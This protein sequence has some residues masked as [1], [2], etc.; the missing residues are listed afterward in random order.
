M[1]PMS[2]A[3]AAHIAGETTTLATCWRLTRT[4]G[5]LRGFTD[6]DEDLVIDGLVYS[7][8]TGFLPTAVEA[9]AD[10][11]VDGLDV[12]GHLDDEAITAEALTAGLFDNAEILI[13]LV[14]WSDLSMGR[15]T[16]RTGTI[17]NVKRADGRFTAEIRGL[18]DK[19]QQSYG[20]IYSRL[21]RVDL[22]SP[23]CGV[24]LAPLT[25]DEEIVE[26]VSGDTFTIDTGRPSGFFTFGTCEFLTGENDGASVEI[27][28]HVSQ[29]IQLFTPMPRPMAEGDEVR[30][31]AG[32]DKTIETCNAKFDNVL[33][34]R[35]EPHIPGNDKVFSYPVRS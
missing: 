4:D 12:D 22:G 35:G 28:Q 26:V 30:L 27:L 6:H 15:I 16:L 17:G 21:C 32:C 29:T 7:A 2:P 31:V 5:W 25:D 11:S 10:L 20:L 33:N 23:A 8:A 13:F 18:A 9:N 19:L 14:N 3:M 34:F 1:K 24:N